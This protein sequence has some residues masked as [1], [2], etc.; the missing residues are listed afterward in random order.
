MGLPPIARSR[1]ESGDVVC[2]V[3][4]TYQLVQRQHQTYRMKEEQEIR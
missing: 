1:S 3:N 4:N 2:L